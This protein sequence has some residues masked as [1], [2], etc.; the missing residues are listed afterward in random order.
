[1]NRTMERAIEKLVTPLSAGWS[2]GSTAAQKE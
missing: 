1:M 2:V